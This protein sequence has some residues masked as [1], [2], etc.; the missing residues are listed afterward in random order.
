MKIPSIKVSS[1]SEYFSLPL[2][3]RTW[4]GFYKEPYSLPFQWGTGDEDGWESFY[5]K[6]KKE[7]PIQWVFRHWIFS[8]DNPATSTLYKYVFWPYRDFKWAIQNWL[9]PCFPRWRKVLPRHKYSDITEMIVNSNFALILDFYYEEVIDGHI[10][11]NAD[12]IH[13]KF[14][15]EL[16]KNVLWIEEHRVKLEEKIDNALSEAH[17]NRKF[18]I[19]NDKKTF[20]YEKTYK[21]HNKLEKQKEDKTNE[22]LKWLVDNRGFFWT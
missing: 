19:K 13:K 5:N 22:I 8:F 21:L 1:V 17:K 20:D 10:D 16:E 4:Y 18:V 6:I 14:K 12:K 2:K 9:N 15:K 3:E 7:F 11:W